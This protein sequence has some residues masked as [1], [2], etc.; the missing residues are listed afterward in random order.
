MSGQLETLYLCMCDKDIWV[1]YVIAISG[2]QE[3]TESENTIYKDFCTRIETAPL[4]P[5]Q[6]E[7][8][9]NSAATKNPS[10]MKREKKNAKRRKVDVNVS[11]LVTDGRAYIFTARL[12]LYIYV[13]V[14]VYMYEEVL[15]P[16]L[17]I[18]RC[19]DRPVLFL[20]ILSS[21]YY[22]RGVYCN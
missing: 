4:N 15:G 2:T 19:R 14:F 9:D 10:K 21:I 20:L 17:A 6:Y 3:L 18:L 1:N 5:S 7:S 16:T 8:A 11:S 13:C 22:L 12:I